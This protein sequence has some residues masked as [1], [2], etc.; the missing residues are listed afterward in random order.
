MREG[1]ERQVVLVMK[2]PANAVE[3]MRVPEVN[4]R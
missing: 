1:E 4:C 3:G 2:D